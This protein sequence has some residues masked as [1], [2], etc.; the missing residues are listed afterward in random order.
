MDLVSS[1]VRAIGASGN[2]LR[3]PEP[4]NRDPRKLKSGATLDGRTPSPWYYRDVDYYCPYCG[5]KT[6]PDAYFCQGCGKKLRER[7]PQSS[8][9]AQIKLYC[10][11]FFIPPLGLWRGYPYLKQPDPKL[12]AVGIVAVTL[13]LASLGLLIMFT[14]QTVNSVNEQLNSLDLTGL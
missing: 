11:S 9:L 8:I 14:I 6:L 4:E 1:V 13:T 10:I 3:P 7:P 12:K 2:G 5:V